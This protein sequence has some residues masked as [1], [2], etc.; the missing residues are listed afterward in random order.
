MENIVPETITAEQIHSYAAN[1]MFHQ[2][3]NNYEVKMA[4]I[5]Q[6]LDEDSA[7]IVIEN[8]ESQVAA[9]RVTRANKDMLYGG[10]WLVGGTVLTLAN[11]G[12]IFWGAIVFGG[13]QFGRGLMNTITR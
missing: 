7:Q 2:D 5:Q 13:I 3:K 11:I 9:A 4:L 8:I 12:F 10:L 1:L 6:G